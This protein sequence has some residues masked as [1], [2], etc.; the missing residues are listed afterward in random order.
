M[1][2]IG[3]ETGYCPLVLVWPP[4]LLLVL[5]LAPALVVM[6]TVEPSSTCE[7][8]AGSVLTTTALLSLGPLTCTVN[9][10]ASSVSFA[11]A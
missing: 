5:L 8:P 10:A 1:L 7:P 3:R 4:L 6:V 2:I 9:P 11:V